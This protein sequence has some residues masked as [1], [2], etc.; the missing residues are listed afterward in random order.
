MQAANRKVISFPPPLTEIK[1]F[2][3]FLGPNPVVSRQ[4]KGYRTL[5]IEDTVIVPD[6]DIK[7]G[8]ETVQDNFLFITI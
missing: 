8:V 7:L 4:T 3:D 2:I 5:L 6:H 1:E